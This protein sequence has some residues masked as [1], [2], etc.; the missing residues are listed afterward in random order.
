MTPRRLAD[1]VLAVALVTAAACGRFASSDPVPAQPIRLVDA[2]EPALVRGGAAAPARAIPRTEWRFDGPAPSPPPKQFAGT[3]GWEGGP[4]VNGLTIRDGRLAGRSTDDFPVLHVELAARP[5]NYDRL[6]AVEVR[7]RVSAG[8]Q[9]SLMIPNGE[10]VELQEERKRAAGFAWPFSAELKP[11][12]EVQTYTLTS[13]LHTSGAEVRHL[14]VRPTDAAGATFE[15]ESVR[16]VYRKEH[17]ATIQ[18][19]VAWQGLKEIYRESLAARAPETIDFTVTLPDR[20]WLDL[21]VGTLE[22][23]PVTFRVA[24]ARAGTPES[25]AGDVLLEHTVTTPHRWEDRVIDLG[26]F[27]GARVRLSM[28][29]SSLEQGALGFWGGP[30]VRTHRTPPASPARGNGSRP[31]GVILIQADTLRRDH[32]DAYGYSRETAP[33]LR[34]LAS[35]GVLFKNYTVQATWTKVSTPSLMT[36]LYPTSHG[37]TDFYHHLPASAHTLA[38]SYRSAGY[39][40]VSFASVLFTGQ[41]SNLHQGFEELHEDGSISTPGSSKTAREYVDRLQGWLERHRDGPFFAFLHVFDPHDPYEPS[42]PYDT[43]WADPARKEEHVRQSAEV[44]KFIKEPLRQLFGMPSRAELIEAKF[45][46]DAY[47]AY[48][49]DWYDGSIR[50]MDVEIRRLLETLR[51][52]GLEE[53]TLIVFLSDHGEEFL[54]HGRM[55][56]GQTVYGELTQVP[57]FMRWPAGLPQGRVVEDLVQ[58]IDVMPT[59]LEI[60]GLTAPDGIQGQSLRPLLAGGAQGEGRW[61]VRPAITEKAITS[62]N[63]GGPPPHDTE[64][65]AIADGQWKLIHNRTRPHGGPEFE[66]YDFV[67]DPLNKTD[68]AAQHPDE[69]AR[70]AKALEGWRQVAA[71]ARLESDAEAT[72]TLS[73]EQLQRLRSLGYIR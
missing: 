18:S 67:R 25:D 23:A 69:V 32:L 20:P 5:D 47:V 14:L 27:A 68:V 55:F 11:G 31:Q 28:S 19:G 7:M 39:A 35:E 63:G 2:F 52:L 30:V 46:P 50:A 70:L 65:Y 12:D 66:L 36:S 64:S 43:Q 17:L 34:Q 33:T 13:P 71:S 16:V 41:F 62:P 6:H 24:V 1:A 73:P 61:K 60:S 42:R 72:K 44:K 49:R 26:R 57:L 48:D 40:T 38:E 21:A 22:D 56:H 59:L 45:D 9:I 4:G 8:R 29:L 15:I 54:D 51:R 58:S 3:Y 10:K 53:N 37:V